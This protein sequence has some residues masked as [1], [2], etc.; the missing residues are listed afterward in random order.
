MKLRSDNNLTVNSLYKRLFIGTPTAVIALSAVWLGGWYFLGLAVILMLILQREMRRLLDKAGFGT[1]LFFPYTIGLFI[2]LLPFLTSK[3]ILALIIFLLFTV[4]QIFKQNFRLHELIST[5]FCGVYIPVGLVCLILLRNAGSNQA[6]LLLTI[7]F[8]LMI[9]G[10]DIFAYLGGKKFGKHP[11]APRISP[12]KTW[13]GIL[14]GFLG[15]AVGLI[16]VR[17]IFNEAT[18]NWLIL[19]PGIVIVSI[20]GPL[21]DLL[22]S[23]LKRAAEMKDSSSV[24]PGHGGFFDRMDA[25]ILAAPAFYLYIEL[26]Q[27]AELINL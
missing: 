23:K 5:F 25:L 17:L 1:D 7:S 4:M 21:G 12:N 24:L 13:E 8:L 27:A 26:L 22:E 10:N 6:G 16:A 2:I 20:F 11:L 14:S 9:W 19:I 15:A 18:V 3:L